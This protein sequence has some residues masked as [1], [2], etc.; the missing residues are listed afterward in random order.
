MPA[1]GPIRRRELIR[2]LRRAG[3][4]GPY[5]GGRHQHIEK[6]KTEVGNSQS[7]SE[8]N[9]QT[10]ACRCSATSRYYSHRMGAPI[11]L[12]II[13]DTQLMIGT[14]DML[15]DYINAAMRNAKYKILSD[16]GSYYGEIPG[17]QGVYANHKTL[18]GCRDE[19]Q[20]VLEG[21]IIL[22]LQLNHTLPEVAG[23]VLA[24]FEKLD[25][26]DF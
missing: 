5:A 13:S 25:A 4:D 16:D 19:L 23:M 15:T 20:S 10:N 24:P 12:H 3:F 11:V 17:I 7:S 14:L 18:E 8:R 22:G 21:W 1:F 9:Q 2:H 6:G 26:E